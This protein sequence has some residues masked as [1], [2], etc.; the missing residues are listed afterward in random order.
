MG[1]YDR[2]CAHLWHPVLASPIH[3]LFCSCSRLTRL[4]AP[5]IFALVACCMYGIMAT[6]MSNHHQAG[7]CGG[8]A[9]GEGIGELFVPGL[10][11]FWVLAH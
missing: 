8:R 11:A 5:H 10:I 7:F 1:A 9:L 6:Q 3:I 2:H 4:W